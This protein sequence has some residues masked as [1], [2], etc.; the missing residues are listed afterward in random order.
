MINQEHF[1][2]LKNLSPVDAVRAFLE[3]AFGI[4]D[5]PAIVEAIRK[6]RRVTRSDDD[7]IDFMADA[8]MEEPCDPQRCLDALAS[9]Q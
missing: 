8:M 3:G 4:G 7:I 1:E 9:P 2:A 6:D 5:E